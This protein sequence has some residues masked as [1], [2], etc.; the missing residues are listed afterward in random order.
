MKK[1]PNR[2]DAFSVVPK[3]VR[4][5]FQIFEAFTENLKPTVFIK[6]NYEVICTKSWWGVLPPLPPFCKLPELW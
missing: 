2:F 6:G 4:D 5:F 3:Q 1:S